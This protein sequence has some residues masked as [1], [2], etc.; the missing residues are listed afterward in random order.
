MR[1]RN[2]STWVLLLSLM[3]LGWL[4]ACS[5]GQPALKGEL[6]RPRQAA[7]EIQ[8]L[9]D[10]GRPFQLSAQRGEVVL[11]FFG[12]TNCPDECPLA[13]SKLK[14]AV[15][16]LGEQAGSVQ[17]VL[18]ST[19]PIRDTPQAMRSYLTSFNSSFIGL[20]GSPDELAKIWEAYGVLVE[21][22]GETHSSLIY[23]VDPQ[24]NLRLHISTDSSPED[25]AL[26]VKTLLT[27]D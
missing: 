1:T 27:E 14:Q 17:V 21:D 7:P 3:A 23:A 22:G 8:L 4:S 5:L 20:P 11:M 15:E 19:D 26:D 12:F 18:V 25:I 13:M 9:D 16:L 2:F 24:G 10:Q 6:V